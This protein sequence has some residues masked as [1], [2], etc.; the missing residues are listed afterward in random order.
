ML[1]IPRRPSKYLHLPLHLY[2]HASQAIRTIMLA[3][4]RLAVEILHVSRVHLP[5]AITERQ[6][7]IVNLG[8]L[9]PV[10]LEDAEETEHG[11]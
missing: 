1:H 11:L 3:Q 2:R 9:L 6:H 4:P 8:I 7:G 10:L 5:P